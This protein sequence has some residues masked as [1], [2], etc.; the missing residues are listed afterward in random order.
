MKSRSARLALLVLFVMALGV[1]AYLFRKSEIARRAETAA[2]DV[3][4]RQ[5][6]LDQ[7]RHPRAARRAAGLRRHRAGRGFLGRARHVDAGAPSKEGLT[8]LRASAI[9]TDAQAALDA[10]AGSLQDFAQMDAPGA[11]LRAR[12]IRTSSRPT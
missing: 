11:R 5:G 7:P 6:A 12:P 8:A 4:Q 2:A 1:T 10:A 9:S 3:L